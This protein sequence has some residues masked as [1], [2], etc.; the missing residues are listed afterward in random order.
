MKHFLLG[1]VAA[2]FFSG[3]LAAQQLIGEYYA[4]LGPQD[5]F[6][7]KGTRLG[8]FCAVLQQDRANFHR[9]GRADDLDQWD[10][11]FSNRAMRA[12]MSSICQVEGGYEY[13]PLTVLSGEPRYVWVRIFGSGGVPSYVLVSEGAG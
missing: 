1:C 5:M 8:S 3:P 12:R 9:F 2:L 10:P 13:I 7:S 6:N 11:I 4:L